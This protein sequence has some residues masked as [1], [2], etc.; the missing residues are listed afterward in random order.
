MHNNN[1][2]R[3]IISLLQNENKEY[4]KGSVKFKLIFNIEALSQK[5]LIIS[6]HAGPDLGT[7]S[8]QAPA[9]PE[10]IFRRPHNRE[11]EKILQ[12]YLYLFLK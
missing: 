7:D 10:K 4:G 8:G 6:T 5:T 11:F 12:I 9:P 3:C 1:V 2:F